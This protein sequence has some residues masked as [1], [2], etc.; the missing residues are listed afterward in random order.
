VPDPLDDAEAHTWLLHANELIVT[1]AATALGSAALESMSAAKERAGDLVGAA[2]VVWASR[3]VRE[4]PAA[5]S[6]DLVFRAAALLESAND[7]SCAE[8][9]E[10][11]LSV[12]FLLDMGSERQGTATERLVAVHRASGIVTFGSKWA[13]W[14]GAWTKGFMT[15]SFWTAPPASKVR[16]GMS[17][18]RQSFHLAVEASALS[19]IPHERQAAAVAPA[20]CS[21]FTSETCDM[22]DWNPELYGG[23][24]ALAEAMEHWTKTER[25]CGLDAKSGPLGIDF[26]MFGSPAIILA[27]YFGRVSALVQWAEDAAAEYREWDLPRTRDYLANVHEHCVHWAADRGIRRASSDWVHL[28]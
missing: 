25:K 12:C 5:A 27:L 1:N 9:E 17:Q 10:E 26:Y 11:V 14:L 16:I 8:F 28:E 24:A 13:E 19:D 2:R 23:E 21:I 4:L 15:W 6:T 7:A 3:Q 18:M 20:H 22:D